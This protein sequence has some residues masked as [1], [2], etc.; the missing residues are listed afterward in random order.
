MEEYAEMLRP[1]IQGSILSQAAGYSDQNRANEVEVWS[2][3][4]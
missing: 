2:F 3:Q 1:Y 4:N